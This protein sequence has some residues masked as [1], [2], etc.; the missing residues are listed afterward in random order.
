M[1][2]APL[3]SALVLNYRS[4]RDTVRCVQALL[5]QTI[6]DRME[7]IVI[8]NH[9]D[10][11]S[12]A[13]IRAQLGKEQRVRIV[14]DR[15]NIGYGAGNNAGARLAR[16]EFLLIIN[17]NNLLPRDGAERMLAYLQ[18]HGDIGIT[19]PTFVY[20]DGTIRPSARA[21]P[22]IPDLL[23][24]R[25]FPAQWHRAYQK[26]AQAMLRHESMEVDWLVGACLMMRT[27]L[28][29]QLGGF[30]ER[31]FLFFEDID[32]CRRIRDAGKRVV[33]LPQIRVPDTDRR[34]SGQSIFSFLRRK[35][36]WIHLQSA[37]Q[38]FWKWRQG[39]LTSP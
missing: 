25:L 22:T 3:V 10:D 35:T 19:G 36:T 14:E 12:I 39:R 13:F 7:M 20:P 27:E 16:G 28:Y 4:H 11:E 6:A 31:F 37:V 34:L 29:R 23:R 21:F 38:Y 26:T 32:L 9:S 15:R 17:P 1:S 2:P 30:D 8:D 24:K 18:S 5:A 33:Y